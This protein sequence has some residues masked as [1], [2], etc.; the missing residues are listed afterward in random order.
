MTMMNHLIWSSHKIQLEGCGH[1]EFR[2]HLHSMGRENRLDNAELDTFVEALGAV[3]PVEARFTVNRDEW[4][5][6]RDDVWSQACE[7]FDFCDK[8]HSLQ[9]Y[10]PFCR[11]GY[12]DTNM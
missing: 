12:Q 6:L 9:L 5:E 2:L 7:A 10:S 3:Q 4:H 8:L 1:P 11:P